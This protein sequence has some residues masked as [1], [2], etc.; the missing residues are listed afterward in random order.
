MF[1]ENLSEI[2]SMA[3]RSVKLGPVEFRRGHVM[4]KKLKHVL[5]SLP[6]KPP[7]SRLEPYTDLIVEMRRRNWPYR[8]I[9]RV[10]GEKCHVR[11]SPSNVHHFL[12]V[13]ALGAK[14]PK[15]SPRLSGAIATARTAPVVQ[16]SGALQRI[17]ALK[18]HLSKPGDEPKEFEYDPSEPLRLGK[19]GKRERPR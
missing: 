17:I 1:V 10:L 15:N 12:K 8:A 2:C 4:D 13:N 3:V 9:A 19:Q 18:Q 5:D 16:D 14:E 7:R 11:A 6:P